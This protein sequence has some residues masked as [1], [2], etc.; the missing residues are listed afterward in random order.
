MFLVFDSACEKHRSCHTPVGFGAD[1]QGQ[2]ILLRTSIAIGCGDDD[3]A[4]DSL[5][6]WSIPSASANC[7]TM[8]SDDGLRRS[9]SISFRY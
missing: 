9:C 6:D 1:Q 7:C 2:I 8:R 3:F 5:D 4:K